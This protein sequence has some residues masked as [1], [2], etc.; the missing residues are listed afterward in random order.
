MKMSKWIKSDKFKDFVE[1]KS[2]EQPR[3]QQGGFVSKWKNPVMGTV[4]QAKTYRVRFLPDK[5]SDFYLKYCYHYFVI[6]EKHYFIFCPKTHGMDEYCPW[7]SVSQILYKG[8]KDDKALAANYKRMEKFI[9]N[10]LVID[11]PRDADVEDEYKVSGTVRLYEFPATIE[12]KLRNEVTD[13]AE[14]YGAK[15]F[16]PEDGFD[17]V[18]KIKAKKP[19]KN[20]KMWPDYSDT[21]F[22]RKSTSLGSEKE[23]DELIEKT[24]NLKEHI[25]TSSLSWDEHKKL[26]KLEGYW[27]DVEDEFNRRTG[28]VSNGKEETSSTS[29]KA[30]ST[31]KEEKEEVD[32]IPFDK[33]PSSQKN[34]PK[35]GRAPSKEMSD[36]DLL[37]ELENM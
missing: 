31:Q 28:G 9:G 37:R 30:R 1:K 13:R 17:L 20:G 2:T 34:D 3:E 4:D 11:D 27:E 7:C 10:V 18:I 23:I 21:Q 16:D 25:E 35:K 26:L 14:G 6:D 12:S 36:E 19:D 8:N 32:D 22:S 33:G 29:T 15:I 24:V 5:N